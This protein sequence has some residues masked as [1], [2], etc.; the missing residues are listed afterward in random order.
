M[1]IWGSGGERGSTC[2]FLSDTAP[3]KTAAPSSLSNRLGRS[4]FSSSSSLSPFWLRRPNDAHA[5]HTH[6]QYREERNTQSILRR[7][8]TTLQPDN[9]PGNRGRV[10]TR[11][12]YTALCVHSPHSAPLRSLCTERERTW[13]WLELRQKREREKERKRDKSLWAAGFVPNNNQFPP[14]LFYDD[15][16][17]GGIEKKREC[18]NVV[19]GETKV[20]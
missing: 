3:R 1:Q 11:P 15:D 2:I 8:T 6:T 20:G 13:V 4:C 18:C 17:T 12:I 19:D 7:P 16:V 10:V 9:E 14:W 5:A